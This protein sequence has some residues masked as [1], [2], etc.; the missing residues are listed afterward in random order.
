MKRAEEVG[1]PGAED[2][3]LRLLHELMNDLPRTPRTVEAYVAYVE[4]LR[5]M[6]ER[7]HPIGVPDHRLVVT[8][9]GQRFRVNVGERLGSDFYYGFDADR[10]DADVFT[11]LI[12]RGDVI[13]DVGANFGYYTVLT[14]V[15]AGATGVVHAFEPDPDAFKLLTENV[16]LNAL[17]R[18]RLY[19]LCLGAEDG[20]AEFYLMDESA[21]SGLSP[22]GRARPR[23]TM[24]TAMRRLDSVL[25][26]QG[27]PAV[28][29]LKI[30]V[31]GHEYAVLAGARRTIRRSRDVIVMM[32]EV[33]AKNLTPE[34]RAMLAG[35]LQALAADG[36]R[37]WVTRL[38]AGGRYHLEEVAEAADM[39]SGNVLLARR[40]CPAESRLQDAIDRLDA[41]AAGTGRG[42][43]GRVDEEATTAT[44][45]A[46]QFA[47]VRDRE[48][49]I[50]GLVAELHAARTDLDAARRELAGARRELDAVQRRFTIKM[51][52][53]LR[54]LVTAW[55]P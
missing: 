7:L 12:G 55:W 1:E 47:V 40:G 44:L 25:E 37:A 22:T 19:E 24:R 53:R 16:A 33:S 46:E 29:C 18:V 14:A 6:R 13:V 5:S 11:A 31:E 43:R 39:R 36:F 49:R 38:D 51:G 54:R 4:L 23:G 27:E 10:T 30:D 52:A 8:P 28:T 2:R 15:A 35:E 41:R 17:D 9:A 21:F 48:A 32:I 42:R 45:L 26:A 3:R 50:E 34:R 20:E